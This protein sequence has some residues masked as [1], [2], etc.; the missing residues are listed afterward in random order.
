M[1]SC[2]WLIKSKEAV[3]SVN[4]LVATSQRNMIWTESQ[5]FDRQQT[6]F[7]N[8]MSIVHLAMAAS[9]YDFANPHCE[10]LSVLAS[11]HL[12]QWQQHTLLWHALQ[13]PAHRNIWIL[14]QKHKMW[15]KVELESRSDFYYCHFLHIWPLGL[16]SCP[17]SSFLK[18]IWYE[19]EFK[20]P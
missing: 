17:K 10:Y 5:E 15:R 2:S 6:T 12:T 1:F 4:T 13:V 16:S 7:V 20:A 9:C 11:I 8:T 18:A 14:L 3:E 19:A